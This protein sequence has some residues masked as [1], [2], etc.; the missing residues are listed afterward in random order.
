MLKLPVTATVTILLSINLSRGFESV[1]YKAWYTPS[2]RYTHLL[3]PTEKNFAKKFAEYGAYDEKESYEYD[4]FYATEHNVQFPAVLPRTFYLTPPSP[5]AVHLDC[6]QT[7][8]PN[9]D[10]YGAPYVPSDGIP[11]PC[12]EHADCYMMREPISWCRIVPAY[13]WTKT[14]TV[15]PSRA[16]S[17]NLSYNFRKEGCHC[18]KK[19]QTCVVNRINQ[20]GKK[21]Y[22]F[23]RPMQN[24]FCPPSYEMFPLKKKSRKT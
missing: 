15:N 22:T 14:D 17:N 18:D 23:C 9:S 10:C 3:T 20:V 21:E 8:N 19:L 4:D 6:Q 7:L 24:W 16:I 11:Q 2:S 13:S 1:T 5:T 12:N